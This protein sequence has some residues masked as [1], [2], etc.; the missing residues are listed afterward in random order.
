M[1]STNGERELEGIDGLTRQLWEPHHLH[2]ISTEIRSSILGCL[3]SLF[4]HLPIVFTLL[5]VCS[6]KR[7]DLRLK[8][9]GRE[10]SSFQSICHFCSEN[11][12]KFLSDDRSTETTECCS[13]SYL[14]LSLDP[15]QG[16]PEAFKSLCEPSSF[17]HTAG[18]WWNHLLCCSGFGSWYWYVYL[19]VLKFDWGTVYG[20]KNRQECVFCGPFNEVTV[21]YE[22][23]ILP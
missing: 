9:E 15:P 13:S 17:M 14:K 19:Y 12:F 20:F 6:V 23:P 22:N 5:I 18:Y 7:K 21:S 1:Y 8:V 4:T 10:W 2:H 3:F 11:S 16:P